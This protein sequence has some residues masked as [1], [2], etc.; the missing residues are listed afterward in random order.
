VEKKVLLDKIPGFIIHNGG[1]IKIGPDG[2]LYVTTGD[3]GEAD[4]AQDLKTLHGKILR[5]TLEGKIPSNNPFPNSYVYS[6]GH[7]NPQGLGRK[8]QTV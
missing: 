8:R 2:Y 5:M 7:R 6:Y 3:A 1:R 4:K